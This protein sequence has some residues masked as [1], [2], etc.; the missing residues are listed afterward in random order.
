[1]IE[2]GC[3]QLRCWLGT[4]SLF[5]EAA[6]VILS[7]GML[8]PR[9]SAYRRPLQHQ[10]QHVAHGDPHGDLAERRA[11][12]ARYVRPSTEPA[13]AQPPCAAAP[14]DSGPLGAGPPSDTATA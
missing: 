6:L 4:V 13:L 10:D 2:T 8:L 14:P 12:R 1:M 5:V 3:W 9:L 7:A 11:T